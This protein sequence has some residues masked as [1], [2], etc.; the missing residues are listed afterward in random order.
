M[1][2][3]WAYTQYFV[4][5]FVIIY[6]GKESEK[7][8]THTH[9]YIVKAITHTH[10]YIVKAIFFQIVMYGCESQTLKETE[11]QRIDAFELWY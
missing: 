10:I 5:T 7:E 4:I 6:K 1:Y 2:S 8:H 9:T 3:T 11:H